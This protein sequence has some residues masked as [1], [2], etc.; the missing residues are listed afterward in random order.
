MVTDPGMKP[1][2][3]LNTQ[4]MMVAEAMNAMAPGINRVLFIREI[5]PEDEL[6]N[7]ELEFKTPEALKMYLT[8]RND[9]EFYRNKR[10]VLVKEQNFH[11][12]ADYLVKY[13]QKSACIT[14]KNFMS[15]SLKTPVPK[16]LCTIKKD[17]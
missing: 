14:F 13:K 7:D 2:M 15:E 9:M 12:A 1:T 8:L 4:C 17:A 11:L 5:M 6:L 3:D 10:D 16:F